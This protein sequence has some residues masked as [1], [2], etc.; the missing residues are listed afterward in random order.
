MFITANM[1]NTNKENLELVIIPPPRDGQCEHLDMS[2]F[3]HF[4]LCVYIHII[5]KL[6]IISNNRYYFVLC[7]YFYLR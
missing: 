2:S 5:F 7:F 3:I 1:D 6:N 4:S